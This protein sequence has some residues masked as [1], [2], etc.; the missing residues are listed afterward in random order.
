MIIKFH[1]TYKLYLL[2]LTSEKKNCQCINLQRS[3]PEKQIF[4]LLE[5]CSSRHEKII[6]FGDFNK[7]TENKV[8]K[9]FLQEHTFYNMTKEDTCFK[10]DGGSCI[11]LRTI[12]SRYS[13]FKTNSFETGLSDHHHMIYTFLKTKFKK[14][15]PK[16]LI[17]HNLKQL[18][19]HQCKLQ[20]LCSLRKK[21]F[22]FQINMLSRKQK[23]FKR[24]KK[25]HFNKNLHKQMMTRLRLK[26]KAAKSKNPRDIVKFK[27]QQN[28]VGNL[29][30]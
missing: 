21:M 28:L 8:M 30:K 2:K 16:K 3:N 22:T 12:N 23:F 13:F 4:Y 24:I 15:E 14:F 27:R 25:Q 5:F 7:G 18:D 26:N 6:I 20:N 29:N 17:Y 1:I 9:D 11:H 10:G 19:S